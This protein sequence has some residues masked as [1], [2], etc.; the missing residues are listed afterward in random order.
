MADS[1]STRQVSFSQGAAGTAGY[2]DAQLDPF[3]GNYMQPGYSS[4]QQGTLAGTYAGAASVPQYPPLFPQSLWQQG[5][6][7]RCRC[8]GTMGLPW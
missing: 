7:S 5:G 1:R 2:L 8:C 4:T 3:T 6:G